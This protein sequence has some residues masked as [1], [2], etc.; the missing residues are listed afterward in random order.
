MLNDLEFTGSKGWFDNFRKIFGFKSVEITGKAASAE[1]E[2]GTMFPDAID[3]V[4]EK[5]G[6]LSEQVL[7]VD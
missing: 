1:Q 4:T 3:K 6:Y 5:K 2:A 7:N